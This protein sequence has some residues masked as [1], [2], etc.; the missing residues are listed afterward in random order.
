MQPFWSL[1]W[2]RLPRPELGAQLDICGIFGIALGTHQV[3]LYPLGLCCR[4]P[5]PAGQGPIGFLKQ[6]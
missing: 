4:L 5:L 1:G 2:S 3:L 6:L